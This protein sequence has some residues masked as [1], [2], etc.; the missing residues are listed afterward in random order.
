MRGGLWARG[1]TVREG[2]GEERLGGGGGGF[3]V[4]KLRD[5]GNWIGVGGKGTG[6]KG[7]PK[8]MKGLET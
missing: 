3:G 7:S 6:W 2:L 1:S 4:G 5:V 8:G